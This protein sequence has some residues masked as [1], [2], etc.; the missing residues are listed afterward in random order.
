MFLPATI[1]GFLHLEWLRLLAQPLIIYFEGPALVSVF[2]PLL[3]CGWIA[4]R[5][6]FPRSPGAQRQ[7]TLL[8]L[9]AFF[10]LGVLISVKTAYWTGLGL[11][12]FAAPELIWPLAVWFLGPQ[13]FS[14]WWAYV[15]AFFG[16][17][18]PDFLLAGS[19]FHW[20]GNFWFGV[21]GAGIGDE[22]FIAPLTTLGGAVAV[23]AI[24]RALLRLSPRTSPLLL[25]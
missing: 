16:E 18:V 13:K 15:F 19:Y 6:P 25:P 10:L 24:R 11:H 3:V 8:L 7:T 22:V 20:S 14:P 4:L 21:G 2:L 12:F 1:T 17:V 5:V 9:V 23:A